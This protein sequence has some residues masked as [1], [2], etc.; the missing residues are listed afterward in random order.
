MYKM[1]K[2]ITVIHEVFY[3]NLNSVQH[4]PDILQY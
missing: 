4:K 2:H 1:N 3:K